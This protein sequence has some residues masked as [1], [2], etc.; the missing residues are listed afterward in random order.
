[1]PVTLHTKVSSECIET[2]SSKGLQERVS[3]LPH[4]VSYDK[5][6]LAS[7]TAASEQ[8][9]VWSDSTSVVSASPN[10]HDLAG[11]LASELDGT[12]ITVVK[13]T[14]IWIENL[15]TTTGETLLIGN[16]SNAIPL[17]KTV[18]DYIKV[19]PG[20][21][22]LWKDPIDGITVTATTGDILRVDGALGTIP[23]DIRVTGRSA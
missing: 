4:N 9:L 20:G 15:S 2:A 17:F 23:Y 7:G 19:G 10:D 5:G 18:G 22:L 6:K 13:V 3:Q 8:D 11:A 12:T 16:D 14:E 1:M 21:C